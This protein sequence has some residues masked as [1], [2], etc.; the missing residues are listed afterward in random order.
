MMKLYIVFFANI[1]LFSISLAKPSLVMNEKAEK[2]LKVRNVENT[3]QS[4]LKNESFNKKPYSYVVL[5]DESSN[6]T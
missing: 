1:L 6:D 3:Q 4:K 5:V 2:F